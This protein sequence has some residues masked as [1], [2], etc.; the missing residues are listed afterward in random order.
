V[1]LASG[2]SK[3]PRVCRSPDLFPRAEEYR[4]GPETYL[5]HIA[6]RNGAE[7]SRHRQPQRQHPGRMDRLRPADPGAGADALELNIY[8]IPT[9]PDLP[10]AEVEEDT[11]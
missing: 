4:L 6:P 8:A 3:A 1:E 9:D 11:T 10:A 2:S 7:D 5:E